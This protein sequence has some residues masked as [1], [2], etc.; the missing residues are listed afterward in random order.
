MITISTDFNKQI[1]QKIVKIWKVTGISNPERCDSFENI[2]A[3]LEKNAVFLTALNND[4]IIATCWLTSD[5]RRLHLHHMA[6]LPEFQNKG[7]AQL[8]IDKA[9][10]FSK[11]YKLQLK[12]EV[13]KNNQIAKNLY[14]KNGFKIL[15]SFITMI[16]RDIN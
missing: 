1:Y 11:E 7:I 2:M 12:L 5:Y 9:K 10:E 8:L 6:V 4:N 15:D 16:R 13:N 3:T 14:L